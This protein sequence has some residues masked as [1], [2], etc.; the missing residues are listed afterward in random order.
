MDGRRLPR[1]E[2]GQKG[3][4][5]STGGWKSA[6]P[7][8][9]LGEE[10]FIVGQLKR[11]KRV[12]NY[13]TV[14]RRKDGTDFPVSLTVSPIRDANGTVVGASKI[15]RDRGERREAQRALAL[16][17]AEFRASFESTTV[18]NVLADSETRRMLRV[19]KTF[20]RMLGYE[21]RERVGRLSPDVTWPEDREAD[22][23]KTW[24]KNAVDERPI[25]A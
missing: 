7:L 5:S 23:A 18:G 4:I 16:N 2:D 22:A 1:W 11:G 25:S 19:N 21:P 10:A 14:R 20:A 17:G 13:E 24:V 12:V 3:T 15:L 9:R 6:A 8:Y